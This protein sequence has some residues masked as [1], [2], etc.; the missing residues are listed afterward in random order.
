MDR[1]G[2]GWGEGRG[3]LWILLDGWLNEGE[4]ETWDV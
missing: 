1:M 3:P 4:I 2:W